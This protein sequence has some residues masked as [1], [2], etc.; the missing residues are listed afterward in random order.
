MKRH[1]CTIQF[2]RITSS[3]RRSI[4]TR[5]K[6]P[7][8]FSTF[9][10][11]DRHPPKGLTLLHPYFHQTCDISKRYRSSI[12]LNYTTSEEIESHLLHGLTEADADHWPVN[13]VEDKQTA[14]RVIQQIYALGPDH[15]HACDT[16]VADIDVKSVGPVG[17][18]KVSV[19]LT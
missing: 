19:L 8:R 9:N 12:P 2:L 10:L 6:I 16:E 15:V 4:H 17:N 1:K 14:D 18:G 7:F 13:L 5:P 11:T 3:L